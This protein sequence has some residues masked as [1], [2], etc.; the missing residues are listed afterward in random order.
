[1]MNSTIVREV[2]QI[3]FIVDTFLGSGSELSST[4]QQL[5]ILLFQLALGS[6]TLSSLTFEAALLL[7][8]LNN[9]ALC[10]SLF[11]AVMLR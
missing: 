6:E 11:S 5:Q 1:M 7:H 3:D 8:I 2:V 10:I 4:S 9:K